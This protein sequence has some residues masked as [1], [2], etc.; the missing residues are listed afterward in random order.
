MSP[1]QTL[2][3]DI[4]SVPHVHGMLDVAND[5]DALLAH[6]LRLKQSAAAGPLAPVLA[7][8][9]ILLLFEKNST[10]TRI[11]L[12]SGIQRL[13]G[14]AIVLDAATSQMAR[15]ESLEDTARVLSRYV[16]AIVYRAKD[17]ASLTGLSE[18]ATVPVVNA[19][20]DRE[21]PLQILADWMTLKEA[22][23]SFE[24]KRFAYVGD[25]NNVCH[26][27][28]LGAP[29]VGMDIAVASPAGFGP[30]ADIVALAR[31]LAQVAGTRVTVTTDPV[32]AVHGAHAV[33][34]DTW[35]SMG[36]EAEQQHR[37]AA[38]RGFTVDAALMAKATK[39]ALFLHCLPGH[40]GQEAT[41]EVAHGPQSRIYDEAENR[42]WTQMALL[43]RLV[44]RRASSP[45]A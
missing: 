44:G 25:G 32:K 33:A 2:G 12:E 16:D 15:G 36:D 35:V 18:H 31:K 27:Y 3:E 1:Q 5:L 7:G 9:T 37:L 11:S 30:D 43:A 24:G 8:K 22:W 41:Y 39:D 6:A 28:L 10:R 21:H 4:L 23:G 26:S 19:L 40:W 20:T 45:A 38:F 13:G 34:T 17:H 14:D 42:M 29:L